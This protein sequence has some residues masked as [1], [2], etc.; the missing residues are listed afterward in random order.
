MSQRI[1]QRGVTSLLLLVAIVIGALFVV[2]TSLALPT[3]VA[4][5]FGAS[6][7]AN[8]FMPRAGYVVFML[9]MVIGVPGFLAVV[10][11]RAF[12]NPQ[13]RINLPHRAYWLAPE[14]RVE[15]IAVL[16]SQ[17]RRF[18]LMLLVFLCYVHWLVVQANKMVP[19]T[20]SSLAMMAGLVV[21][22][23]GT[24]VWV[25]LLIGRFRRVPG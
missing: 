22:L 24:L 14:R 10:P 17:A 21:F 23:V 2:V 3:V 19:P 20:L 12:H 16:S 15:T 25:V 4:S 8:G 18:S 9:V 5:H 1:R 13:A 7:N 11:L 6:G